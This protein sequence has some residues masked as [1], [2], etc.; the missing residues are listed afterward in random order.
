MIPDHE[1]QGHET[2]QDQ[3]DKPEVPPVRPVEDQVQGGDDINYVPLI[4]DKEMEEFQNEHNHEQKA[5]GVGQEMND[6]IIPLEHERQEHNEG[7]AG[8]QGADNEQEWG[9]AVI[10]LLAH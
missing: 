9:D 8:D 1:V 7:A 6:R 2:A 4:A 5:D 3:V 10:H